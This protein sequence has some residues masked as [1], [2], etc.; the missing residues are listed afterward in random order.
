MKNHNLDISMRVNLFK[1][2][3]FYGRVKSHI[4]EHNKQFNPIALAKEVFASCSC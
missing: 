1:D 3:D 2:F 4:L